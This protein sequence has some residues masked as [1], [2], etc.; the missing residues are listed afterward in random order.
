MKSFECGSSVA[1]VPQI[2]PVKSA[3]TNSKR[4]KSTKLTTFSG[5]FSEKE[6]SACHEESAWK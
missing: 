6:G 3:H 4:K 1:M 5:V 2:V